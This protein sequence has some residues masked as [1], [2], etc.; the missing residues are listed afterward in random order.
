MLLNIVAYIACINIYQLSWA[1][2]SLSH[3]QWNP[4]IF[5]FF[6][7]KKKSCNVSQCIPLSQIYVHGTRITKFAIW[8]MENLVDTR[9]LCVHLHV[10]GGGDNGWNYIVPRLPP[11]IREYYKPG[12]GEWRGVMTHEGGQMRQDTGEEG[13]SARRHAG[14]YTV[15]HGKVSP[16]RSHTS[17]CSKCAPQQL[18]HASYK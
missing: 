18:F 13:S 16:P 1:Q 3:A 15:S 17:I 11:D 14:R 4:V 9:G 8:Q 7:K 2:S 12:S 5:G 6:K 10:R